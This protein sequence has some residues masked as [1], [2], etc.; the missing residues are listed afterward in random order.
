MEMVRPWIQKK[1][2]KQNL[3]GGS[4]VAFSGCLSYFLQE[5]T[6]FD[7]IYLQTYRSLRERRAETP[8]MLAQLSNAR[9]PKKALQGFAFH[10][11]NELLHFG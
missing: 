8:E 4:Q 9:T 10:E 11:A 3:F 2:R 5:N 1:K 6:V 7:G